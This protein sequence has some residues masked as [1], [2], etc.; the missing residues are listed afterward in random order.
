[1]TTSGQAIA[2]IDIGTNSVHL[3]IARPTESGTPEII[4]R[5]KAPVRLGSGARDM[6]TLDPDA[7]LRAIDALGRFRRIAEAHDAEIVAV[8]TSAVREAENQAQFIDAA[9]TDARVAVDVI[10][11]VE[12]ARLI[13]LGALGAV[14]AADRRHLVIDIGGGST[15]FVVGHGTTPELARSL[16]LGHIRLTERFF[17]DGQITRKA[18]DECRRY[19]RAFLA[20]A[21]REITDAG[22]EIAIGCSGTIE[23]LAR[24]AAVEAG[25]AVRTVDNLILTRDGLWT[26]VKGLLAADDTER[27]ARTPGLDS[28]RADV[29]VGG[30]VLLRQIFKVL[31]IG[32]M[33]VSP[34]ALREGVVLDQIRRRAGGS[35]DALHHLG[36]LRRSSVEAVA[37]RYEED[38][39]HAEHATDLALQLFDALRPR[40]GYGEAERD[41]LEAAGLLHNVGRFIAHAAHHKHSYYLIRHSEHLAGFN[42]REIELIAQVARYHRKSN[43]RPKH[44]EF[45]ALSDRD[46]QRVRVLAGILR[47]AIGLDR[48]YRRVV[49]EVTVCV[50]DDL[51][52]SLR[53]PSETD[54]ELEVFTAR[55]RAGL[56]ELA[57]GARV[58]FVVSEA[59]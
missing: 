24:M 27:R 57:L 45:A 30:A 21:A 44:P 7:A 43:P 18:V 16:K 19:V 50:D 34:A 5:E 25:E 32:E 31:D 36:D 2:A 8:A 14:P 11:G 41:V 13:H 23:N 49:H 3:V 10:S 38:F 54:V 9:W 40:H 20:P 47:I 6:K 42:E 58:D 39:T 12:E 59:G 22:F 15:E 53:V 35:G 52:I 55:E 46:R 56:L 1:M 51:L 26:V 48:T 17:P 37:R 4:T 28:H 29:I 33:V